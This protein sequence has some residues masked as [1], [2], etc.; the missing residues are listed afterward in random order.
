MHEIQNNSV[1]SLIKSDID[2]KIN[3][4]E[5]ILYEQYFSN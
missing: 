2:F 1:Y 5:K 4:I 3:F